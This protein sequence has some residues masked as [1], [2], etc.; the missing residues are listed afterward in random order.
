MLLLICCDF[1]FSKQRASMLC[2]DR[3]CCDRPCGAIQVPTAP[4]QMRS[5][6]AYTDPARLAR[7]WTK[8]RSPEIGGR[9]RLEE[10]RASG[11]GR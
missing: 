3:I 6:T 9:F 1:V 8:L 10:D 5:N 11:A 2:V 7:T 4:S